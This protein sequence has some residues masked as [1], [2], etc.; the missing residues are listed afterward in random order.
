MNCSP[1]VNGKTPI[2][3]SC[4]TKDVLIQLKAY[5][6]SSHP[7]HPIKYNSPAK[8]WNS[9]RHK[10][11]TCNKEDCWLNLIKDNKVRTALDKYL[12][13]PDQPLSWKK[14]PYTWLDTNDIYNV[15][16]QYEDLYPMFIAIRPTAID[17]DTKIGG[18]YSDTCVTDELCKFDVKQLINDGKTKVGIVFNLDKHDQPG[19]HWV[20]LFIDL[21]DQ[22]AF[23]M[24][25]AGD[26]TPKEIR[27]LV[28]RVIQQSMLMNKHITFYENYPMQHQYGNT[29]C[30]VYSLF[31]IITMLTG[32]TDLHQFTDLNDKI[33]FFK[34]E[35][36]PD[37]YISKFRKIYF[38][39]NI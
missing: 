17:F 15:L 36:I 38:N 8:I 28:E 31:F 34:N 32:K 6:N 19:S 24:D 13:A 7:L 3:D 29:E 1:A 35:R 30:G 14:N 9:L 18:V 12:F 33:G 25:S 10:L 11:R 22:Y 5:Y 23:Y 39:S 27:Q 20:S 2:R 16:R 4:L 37:K 26:P 21:D